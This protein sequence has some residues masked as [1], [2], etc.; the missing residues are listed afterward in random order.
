MK[1]KTHFLTS[2]PKDITELET[3]IW[4]ALQYLGKPKS[5]QKQLLYATLTL[6]YE[7]FL[8]CDHRWQQ[9]I[10]EQK[11]LNNLTFTSTEQ[12]EKFLAR[13]FPRI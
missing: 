2:S 9:Y 10:L 8:K 13:K 7:L 5:V 4:L 12:N 3:N 1:L 6:L 11:D